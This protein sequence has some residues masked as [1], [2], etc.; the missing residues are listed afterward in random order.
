MSLIN[1]DGDSLDCGH[2]V[3]DAFDANI[4][5]WWH[6]DDDN[7]TQMSYL[8][9]GVNIRKSHKKT[10]RKKKLMFGSIYVL[11]VLYIRTIHLKNTALLFQELTNMSKIN[12]MKKVI[13]YLDV[14][15]KYF[16]VRQENSDEIQTS[17]S[18]IKYELKNYIEHNISCKNREEKSFWLNMDE[19][20]KLLTVNPMGK[21]ITKMNTTSENMKYIVDNKK[22]YVSTLKIAPVNS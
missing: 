11:F 3:S 19:L 2:C 8:P 10:K 18:F 15:R 6:C 14:F 1:H 7:I 20:N 21:Q 17:I 9:K 12:H 16:M 5:I 22:T 13:E 4:G